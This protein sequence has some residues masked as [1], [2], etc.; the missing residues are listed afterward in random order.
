MWPDAWTKAMLKGPSEVSNWGNLYTF[1]PVVSNKALVIGIILSK[2]S[3][4]IWGLEERINDQV[5][6]KQIAGPCILFICLNASELHH[7]HLD[8]VCL[9]LLLPSP[10][11]NTAA[12]N[13][14]LWLLSDQY[15]SWQE[16]AAG[17][18]MVQRVK[19]ET[20]T[21][22]VL[23]AWKS[24]AAHLI[25]IQHV[26]VLSKVGGVIVH[27]FNQNLDGL[28]HLE[29]R[30]AAQLQSNSENTTTH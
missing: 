25:H 6:C 5:W 1:L 7:S 4:F 21:R 13:Q 16:W 10:S 3:W 22:V 20:Q 12:V 14:H 15:W 8:I 18:K 29:E 26:V 28:V 24:S 2:R 11:D 19:E 23:Q 27:V 17:H 9:V 30:E